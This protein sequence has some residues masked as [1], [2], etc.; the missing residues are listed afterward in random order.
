[1]QNCAL[2]H[3]LKTQCRLCIDF[4]IARDDRRVL[5]DKFGQR[6]FQFIDFGHTG[7]QHL[8][9]GRI[10]QQRQQQVLDGDELVT[11]LPRFDKGHVQTNFEFLGDHVV[12]AFRDCGGVAGLAPSYFNTKND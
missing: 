8:L 7:F 1:M 5:L 11:L 2:D 6:L 4:A 10:F 3:P 12:P 9:R